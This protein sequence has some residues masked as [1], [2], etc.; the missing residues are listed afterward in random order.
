MEKGIYTMLLKLSETTQIKV[1]SLG[2]I[3]FQPSYYAYT[4]SALG[5]GGFKRVQRHLKVAARTNLTRRWHLD[6]FIPETEVNCVILTNTEG[7]LE[8]LIASEI[9]RGAES[10]VGF[11]STDCECRSHL[12]Y[13]QDLDSLKIIAIRAHEKYAPTKVS[14]CD[15]PLG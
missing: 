8:C 4:G 10:I 12:H 5:S 6:Y 3:G 1:G 11:G 14:I 13:Y 9:G 7:D 15:S 2:P